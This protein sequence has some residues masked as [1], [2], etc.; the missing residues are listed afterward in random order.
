LYFASDGHPGMGG[1][2]LYVSRM[3]PDGTWSEAVNL[4]YPINSSGDE[5]SLQVFPDG[6]TALFA[7]DREHAGD[8]DLWQFTLPESGAADE[9]TLWRGEV[10]ESASGLPVSAV[11]Q[12]LNPEGE[13][14]GQQTSDAEDG[15]FTLSFPANQPVILQVEQPG[16]V[17]FSKSYDATVALDAFVQIPLDELQIG[18]VFILKDVRFDRSS[19]AL[20]T[21]FQPD[22]EQLARTLL[23]SDLRIRIVGHTDG[24]GSA[25]TNQQLSEERARSVV[26]Y[27]HSLGISMDR[28]ESQGMGERSP[29]ETNETPEGRARNRRTEIEV[30]D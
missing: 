23:T 18:S 22:L 3:Q 20:D 14:I 25:Q 10:I 21:L 19:A 8:L 1:M 13:N 12:V 24:E 15:Q 16:Y 11:V 2:D 30:I 6:R 29:I 27:L 7:T 5:N 17:F 28:M 26:K 4:G 9:I